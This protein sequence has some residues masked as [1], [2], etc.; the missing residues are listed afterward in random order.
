MRQNPIKTIVFDLVGVLFT[1][2]KLKALRKI[3]LINIVLYYL[4]HR[5]D[6]IDDTLALLNKMRL[7]VP[8]E[9]QDIVTYKGTQLPACMLEWQRGTITCKEALGRVLAFYEILDSQSYFVNKRQ[10][11]TL[12]SLSYI[13]LD[14]AVGG[15][16]F[17]LVSSAEYMIKKLKKN[18]NYKLYILSNI[19]Q[20][21]YEEIYP[22][23]KSFFDLFD[24]IVT[25]YQTHLLKPGPEIFDYL[26]NNYKLNPEN[27]CYIDDQR[28]NLAT[29]QTFGM[30]TL[31]CVKA[32]KLGS[33][34]QKCGL[35]S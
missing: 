32:K 27:C 22:K 28:E 34:L 16:I 9:F 19:D 1:V 10:K 15:E 3:G 24:G 11:K 35:M 5:K 21:T 8:G 7:E 6:P 17:K 12:I 4:K 29:A 33:L 26:I 30:M 13:M 23:H 2:D 18:S 25:S 31:L 20:E 14:S